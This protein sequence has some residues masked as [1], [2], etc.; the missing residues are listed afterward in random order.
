MLFDMPL[1]ELQEYLPARNEPSNFDDF[2]IGTLQET[3]AFS[4]DTTMK[5][6]DFGLKT[7]TTY[8]VSFRGF[9]GHPIKG[10]FLIPKHIQKP[11]PC[12]IE[13][14]G[15]GG[16]RSLPI[17]W[18][19][20]SST[21][22]AHFIMDTRG[23]GSQGKFGDTPDLCNEPSPPQYP[24]FMTKGI[25]DPELYY[26]RRV[27]TDAARA[28]QAVKEISTV[29]PTRV[30]LTGS[31]Q[32]G[33]IALAANGLV[34]D[35]SALLVDAPFLCHYRRAVTITDKMPYNEIALYCK[36]HR[37]KVE[38]IFHTLDYFDGMNFAARGKANALFSVG[39][40]DMVCPPSS[41][42]A[43]YNHYA[44]KKQIKVWTFN[45]HEAGGTQHKIEQIKFLAELWGN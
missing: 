36:T 44:G 33:G 15:Y 17:D 21:G 19:L 5:E 18:L 23:Q 28:V 37:D 40:M 6:V 22:Y 2:W 20:W 25:N 11:I 7:L 41:V 12:V 13:Y 16:G 39:L 8:D 31:S 26:Y 3:N 32:G 30:A 24:G 45:E 4:I 10:W 34:K 29:D 42:F 27:F 38:R 35:I 43:A 1:E 14:I 9:A